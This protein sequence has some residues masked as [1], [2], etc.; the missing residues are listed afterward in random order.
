MPRKVLDVGQCVPDHAAIRQLIESNF[1]ATVAQ[2]HQL[3]DTLAA[4]RRERFDLV[5]VNRK[6][7]ADYSDGLDILRAIK[8]DEQLN[9]T[10]VMLVTN[11]AVYQQSAVAA[12]AAPG[13]GKA[14]LND[15]RTIETLAQFL[16][17]Q[18]SV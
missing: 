15:P 3:P 4:L 1:D 6:L 18:Q 17:P 10:P 8:A 13:F 16:A 5:L 12:G 7:D 14:Q 9:S 11:Y 2:S